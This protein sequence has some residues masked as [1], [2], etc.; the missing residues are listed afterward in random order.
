[1][2]E[3]ML[4]RLIGP[5]IELRVSLAEG[6]W[7]VKVD[8]GQIEQIVVNLAINA[9]DAMPHGGSLTLETENV[10]LHED[11]TRHHVGLSPGSHARLSVSDTGTGI[12]P[13]DLPR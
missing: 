7:H 13:L 5:D 3:R 8:P 6:L 4:R 11:Y 12:D 9:R 2:L 10:E 1:N